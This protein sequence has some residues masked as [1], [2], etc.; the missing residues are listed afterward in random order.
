VDWLCVPRF[1]SPAVFAALLGGDQHGRWLIGPAD[2]GRAVRRCYREGTLVL[3]TEFETA[4]GAVRITDCMPIRGH[5]VDIVRIVEGLSG[6]V[7]MRTELVVAFDYGSVAPWIRSI[8]GGLVAIAGPD[9]LVLQSPVELSGDV[10]PGAEFEVSAGQHVPF[11]LAWYPSYQKAPAP[12]DCARVVATTTAWWM[13][14]S[15]RSTYAGEWKDQVQRSL[16]TLKALTYAPTGGIV[17]APT[18]S[19]PEWPGSVRNWDYRF[20]WVRDASLSLLALMG[21]GYVHEAAAW[22][23][24]VLR[25]VAGEPAKLQIMYGLGGER[26][27]TEWEADWLPGYEDSRPVHIG[28]AASEQFQLDVFGELIDTL[29]L[30]VRMGVPAAGPDHP[31]QGF[32]LALME[33]LEGAWSQPD[34]GI[35]EVRGPRQHFTHS[36]VMAW[37]AFDRAV[38]FI[39]QAGTDGPVDRFRAVRDEIHADVCAKAWNPSKQA[40]TQAYGSDQLDAAVL[41]IPSVGFLPGTDP[42]VQSTVAAV[43]RELTNDGF[44]ARYTTE[45][46]SDGLPPGEGA[47]LPCS[48]WLADNLALMGRYDE[49]AALFERLLGLAND[50]GLL[51]EEYDPVSRRQLGNFPQAFT[52]LALVGTALNLTGAHNAPAALR[53][54]PS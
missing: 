31:L 9:A 8:D 28:N 3:E 53:A 14:W 18:T 11:R 41:M 15:S 42:R 54:R 24:W 40:F 17:A 21:A 6:R 33:F 34:D 5:T 23:D 38:Q 29:H 45:T 44:V 35:W 25:A 12:A 51:A 22:R 7:R 16:I 48:F 13:E 37:V 47:F 32:S 26:R 27:L 50:V 52:H 46:V 2:G 36:K 30:A 39:E 43:Q 4:D 10:R 1:D 20:C 49:A 19:L